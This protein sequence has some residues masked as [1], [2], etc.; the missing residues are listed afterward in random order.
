MR[1]SQNRKR[2]NN[3]ND[4]N[5][6]LSVFIIIILIA[7]LSVLLLKNPNL[8]FI[9]KEDPVKTDTNDL[10]LEEGNIGK[11]PKEKIEDVEPKVESKGITII[12]DPGHGGIDPGK[13]GVNGSL[14]KEI[15]L[16]IALKLT[17][18]LESNGY[19]V[20]MTRT[21]DN[22]LY[23]EGDSNKKVADLRKRVEIVNNSDAT[24]AISIH[25]NSFTQESSKG[26]QVFYFGNSEESKKFALIMQDQLKESLQDG[27]RREAKAD[28]SYYLLKN[29]NCPIIIVECGFLS[30]YNEANLLI[31]ESYQEKL[32]KA[33][34]L[35]LDTYIEQGKE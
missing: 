17:Q 18:E 10:E 3:R 8:P 35:G 12:V 26:A 15:N 23:L 25:Q 16:S 28:N 1:K 31:E 27:N 19:D 20:I 24:V 32:A 34:Y 30:N 9:K 7:I 22:G 5:N 21:D 4:L 11:T 29:T 2:R 14:E 33:I 6:K 13:V